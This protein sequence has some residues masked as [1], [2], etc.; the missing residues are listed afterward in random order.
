MRYWR[1]RHGGMDIGA[2]ELEV[3][4]MS[5]F[6]DIDTRDV[7][8]FGRLPRPDDSLPNDMADLFIR[9]CPDSALP[10][11][12]SSRRLLALD[13]RDRD[14]SLYAVQLSH[15]GLAYML[16]DLME[17]QFITRLR[18]NAYSI[19]QGYRVRAG[20]LFDMFVYGVVTDRVN[21]L[22]I[23]IK[24]EEHRVQIGENGYLLICQSIG[25]LERVEAVRCTL[26]DGTI[27]S[28][29][30]VKQATEM[31]GSSETKGV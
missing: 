28:E 31:K 19:T 2:G 17:P 12:G 22:S 10:E 14:L 7:S 26:S 20:E 15:R 8:V 21:H 4:G 25:S 13:E 11:V 23:G 29:T 16:T 3:I 24:G 18:N 1:K 6:S 27:V 9:E 30:F 5:T